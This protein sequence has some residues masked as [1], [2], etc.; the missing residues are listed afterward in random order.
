M[1]NFYLPLQED[2]QTCQI[3]KDHRSITR[4]SG[5]GCIYIK[6]NNKCYNYNREKDGCTDLFSCFPAICVPSLL[7][8]TP[9]FLVF[10]WYSHVDSQPQSPCCLI[11][12]SRGNPS[13]WFSGPCAFWTSSL[14]NFSALF[15][16]MNSY[17]RLPPLF[18]RGSL[19]RLPSHQWTSLSLPVFLTFTKIN[20]PCNSFK[21][22][23]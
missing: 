10:E 7:H 14:L 11:G 6:T 21:I 15:Q 23:P 3:T 19:R 8:A 18:T 5:S 2:I 4:Y 20:F 9:G 17:L 22:G 1:G 16:I 12:S 13:A